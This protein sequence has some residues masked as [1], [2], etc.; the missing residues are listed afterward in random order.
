MWRRQGGSEKIAVVLR[1]R[2]GEEWTLPKGKLRDGESWEEAAVREVGEET[3]C[4]V[5]RDAFAGG[6][7]YEVND[8]PKV[9]L[10]WHMSLVSEGAIAMPDDEVREVRWLTPMEARKIL[11]HQDERELLVRGHS[12]RPSTARP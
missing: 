9:V 7:V 4:T 12:R 10:F 1:A 11:T 3:G 6:H 8:E 2:Y 5:E